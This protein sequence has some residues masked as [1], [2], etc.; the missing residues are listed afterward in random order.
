MRYLLHILSFS[1]IFPLGLTPAWAADSLESEI[2]PWSKH[3]YASENNKLDA[4]FDI[5]WAWQL[6]ESPEFA[7]L[8]GHERGQDRWSDESLAAYRRRQSET[9]QAGEA[10]A[11][12]DAG[13]LDDT[14]RL[15]HELISQ[16]FAMEVAGFR[17]QDEYLPL[18]QMQGVQQEPA[19]IFSAMRAV[20]V[21]DFENMLARLR[22]LPTLIGQIMERMEQGLVAGITPPKITL[23]DVP[24]QVLNLI[25]A[26]A[27]D[28]PLLSKFRKMP[29]D[30]PEAVRGKLRAQAETIVREQVN[31]AYR[32][33]HDFLVER[34]IPGARDS[35]GLS[36][37]AD[38]KD[39]YAHRA[40]LMT[41]TGLTPA[42]IHAKGL[43]EVKRIRG[44]MSR[45]IQESGFKGDFQAFIKFLRTDERFYFKQPEDLLRGY[46]DI[47]K[48]ADAGLVKLFGHL[49]RLPYGVIKVPAYAE[50]SQTTAYYQSGSMDAGRPGYFYANT[51]DLGS[52][53]KWEMEALSLHEAVPGHHLQLA[54]AEELEGV[55]DLRR[56]TGY[57]A[58]IE[59]WGLYSESLGEEMGFYADPYAKFGQ[60]TYEMWRAIRLVVDTGMHSLGWSRQ[61]AIDY[62]KANAPKTEHDIVVEV[63]RYIVWPGQ[64]L[65]YKIGELKI[66]ELRARA[67]ERLGEHFDIRA[68]HDTVLGAGAL[69][70][71]VLE[72]RINE[73]IAAR[74]R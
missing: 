55:H 46:R 12:V 61:R 31:P 26:D 74:S 41:T 50:K 36:A 43:A 57:T 68:F 34:Y 24:Q 18:N 38:G 56:H 22:A 65:A 49:P 19:H 70:L 72:R 53:P 66:K 10:L 44:E 4:L 14:H 45:V 64:A 40:K 15:S 35:I 13:K 39:W 32:K 3:S 6:R 54:I 11:A 30:I 67:R 52:R 25:T 16:R 37:L 42:Q 8:V 51:Y 2:A 27:G 73:W 71:D 47:C 28:S 62:F 60:L 5:L 20:K 7:T 9:R 48:R 59:G 29:D 69:P 33:L 17:F 21:S 23:R 58:F 1:L 63:D